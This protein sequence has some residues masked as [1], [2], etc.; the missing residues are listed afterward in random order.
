M[1]YGTRTLAFVS[2]PVTHTSVDTIITCTQATQHIG[3][4]IP[5]AQRER[6]RAVPGEQEQEQARHTLG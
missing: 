2:G 5:C 1:D 4:L 6:E 3:T